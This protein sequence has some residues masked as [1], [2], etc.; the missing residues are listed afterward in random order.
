MDMNN[1]Q[2]RGKQELPEES[3]AVV[4][5]LTVEKDVIFLLEEIGIAQ[6]ACM[7]NKE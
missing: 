1:A 2:E 6:M 3:S 4:E 5:A 7:E